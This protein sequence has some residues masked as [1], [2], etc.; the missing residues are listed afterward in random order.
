LTKAGRKTIFKDESRSGATTKRPCPLL[1]FLKKLED[2]ETLLSD[3]W[4][5]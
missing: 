1:R 3:S 5:D 2:G 4:T